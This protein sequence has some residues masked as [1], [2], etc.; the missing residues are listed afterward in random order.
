MAEDSGGFLW[1]RP[2]GTQASIAKVG[3]YFFVDFKCA[4]F[5]G[6]CGRRLWSLSLVSLVR[7][8]VLDLGGA[9]ARARSMRQGQS[10]CTD[11]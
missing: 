7:L 9:W 5:D 11:S 2:Q 8:Y 6:R 10:A 4:R 1:Q 3:A